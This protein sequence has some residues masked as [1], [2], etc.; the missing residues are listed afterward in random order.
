[1]REHENW[2][3]SN[4]VKNSTISEESEIRNTNSET[5]EIQLNMKN[6]FNHI[7]SKF[8]I[9]RS[10]RNS[11]KQICKVIWKLKHEIAS[12]ATDSNFELDFRHNPSQIN[13]R[14][15]SQ[16]SKVLKNNLYFKHNHRIV[17][18][19]CKEKMSWSNWNI[20]HINSTSK[21]TYLLHQWI[22]MWKRNSISSICFKW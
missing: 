4:F 14:K 7:H 17:Q 20:I 10:R 3:V 16:I 21:N 1:M 8:W 2:S 5:R 11:N 18:R 6:R 9:Y 12:N 19:K 22:Q 15:I 13:N